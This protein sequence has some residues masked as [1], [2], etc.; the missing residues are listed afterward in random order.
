MKINVIT[1]IEIPH[2]ETKLGKPWFIHKKQKFILSVTTLLK[3]SILCP[4]TSSEF[5][6][7]IKY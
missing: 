3:V 2:K 7:F 1:F 4:R 6:D 5:L